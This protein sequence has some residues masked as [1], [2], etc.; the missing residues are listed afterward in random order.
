MK[1]IYRLMEFLDLNLYR[2]EEMLDG[3][4]RAPAHVEIN[5]MGMLDAIPLLGAVQLRTA[6][7][8]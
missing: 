3:I 8:A 1:Y 2:I 7:P 4:H 6:P 5:T